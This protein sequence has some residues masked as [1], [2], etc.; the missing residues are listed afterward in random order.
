MV[1]YPPRDNLLTILFNIPNST[2][3]NAIFFTYNSYKKRTDLV[4]LLSGFH[5]GFFVWGGGVGHGEGILLLPQHES[6]CE[7]IFVRAHA[8]LLLMQY[9]TALE[10]AKKA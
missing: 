1:P 9:S 5:L 3:T 6:F 10:R 2:F 4:D 8:L 7:C